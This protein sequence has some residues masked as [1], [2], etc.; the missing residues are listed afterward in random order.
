MNDQSKGLSLDDIRRKIDAC[1]DAML[2]QLA[3][4]FELSEMVKFLK[5]SDPKSNSL[6]LRPAREMSILRRLIDKAAKKKLNPE[7]LVRLWPV[8]ISESSLVQAPVTIHVSKRV[9][10]SVAQRQRIRDYFGAMA[11]EEC[12][13]EAQALLQVNDAACD[14]CIVETESEWVDPFIAGHAGTAK[15]MCALPV[16]RGADDPDA[17]KLLV[18][19]HAPQEATGDDETIVV[20]KG[21]LPRDFSPV[22]LWQ[23]KSGE[24]RIAAIP[25]FLDIS[26]QPFAS[27]IRSNPKLGLRLIGRYPSAITL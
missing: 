20:S 21:A 12:R 11:I 5:Q 7:L 18:I 1:D 26:D 27:L 8:I 13:D 4:R 17:P 19:G 9:Y 6:P 15:V 22:P 16:L 23:A 24:Y 2:D 14:I 3:N 10:G 25:G